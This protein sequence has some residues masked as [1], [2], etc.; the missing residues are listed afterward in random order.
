MADKIIFQMQDLHKFYEQREI[1]K[2]IT[3]QFLEGAK[4]G[5]IGLNG[6]GKT[7]LLRIVAGEDKQFEGVAKANNDA[8]VGYLAQEPKLD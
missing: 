7:T 8:T 1:L 4:I 3:L 5:L 6:A 2:G